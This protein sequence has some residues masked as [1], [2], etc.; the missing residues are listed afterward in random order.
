MKIYQVYE[1]FG[2]ALIYATEKGVIEIANNDRTRE[3]G[4]TA[5]EF[6]NFEDAKQFLE[7]EKLIDTDLTEFENLEQVRE[8]LIQQDINWEDRDNFIITI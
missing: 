4:T 6:T 7:E 5:E 2:D 8:Y 3:D 1:Q